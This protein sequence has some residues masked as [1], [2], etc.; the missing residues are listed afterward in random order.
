PWSEGSEAAEHRELGMVGTNRRLELRSC[1]VEVQAGAAVDDRRGVLRDAR[2]AQPACGL[3]T[4]VFRVEIYR[5]PDLAGHSRHQLPA[6]RAG[7]LYRAGQD[8]LDRRQA[9]RAWHSNYAGSRPPEPPLGGA[10][11]PVTASAPVLGRHVYGSQALSP[12]VV[13]SDSG[14]GPLL[15]VTCP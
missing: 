12:H 8:H 6:R 11:V 7:F 9:R 14:A 5:A 13:R 2:A 15:A 1:V 3:V 10:R 4:A